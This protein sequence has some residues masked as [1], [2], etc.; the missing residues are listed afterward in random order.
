MIYFGGMH[1][2]ERQ[3]ILEA[4]KTGH[5]ALCDAI[6]GIGEDLAI[7]KP[8]PASW[9]IVECVEHLAASEEFLFSR[10]TR[11]QCCDL[12]QAN[13]SREAVI[14]D[15]GLDR[16]RRV[17]SPDVVRPNGRFQSLTEA[18]GH[19]DAMRAKTVQFVE[20][21]SGDP[22]CWLT[23]HPLISG[24]VNCYEIL[25]II[26]VHPLRHAEQIKE[27]RTGLAAR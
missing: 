18:A 11:A 17:E 25:L 1:E 9:S 24:P 27:I 8:T 22:R 15:R 26:S 2:S 23:D 4:L 6:A 12:P 21:F 5:D 14:V 16:T 13:Q 3:D 10:L 20:S 7:C 19:F